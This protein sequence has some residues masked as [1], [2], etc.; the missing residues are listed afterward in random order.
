MILE[1]FLSWLNIIETHLE[2]TKMSRI[3]SLDQIARSA[4]K[5][6][7]I[8]DC[9]YPVE[10]PSFVKDFVICHFFTMF[11]YDKKGVIRHCIR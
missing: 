3:W 4:L 9:F 2:I 10:D 8:W 6:M 1:W 7:Q 11:Y 5:F